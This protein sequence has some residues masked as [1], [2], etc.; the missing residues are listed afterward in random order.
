[1]PRGGALIMFSFAVFGITLAAPRAMAQVDPWEFEVYPYGTEKRG[2]LEFETDNAVVPNGHNAGGDGTAAGTYPSQG[3][4]YDQFELTYGLT[5]RIEAAAYLN[6]AGR[7]DNGYHYAGSNFRLRG[8]LFKKAALPVDLGWS[9]ELEWHKTPQFDGDPLDL[10]LR[11]IIQKKIG[12]WSILLNPQFEKSIFVGPDKNK[13]FQFGYASG[14]YYR[15]SRY[16][17]C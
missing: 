17:S 2:V 16:L 5:D 8:R 4:W 12:S 3:M 10:E 9:I 14:I 13:G 1:M 6:M 7:S 11:P 15:W